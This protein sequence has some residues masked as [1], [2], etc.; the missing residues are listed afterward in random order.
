MGQSWNG[1]LVHDA[2]NVVSDI[3]GWLSGPPGDP[4]RIRQ[5][6]SQIETLGD[7]LDSNRRGLNESIDEL[8]RSWQGDGA[9]QFRE[10]WYGGGGS[11]ATVMSDAHTQLIGFVRGLR[12]YADKLEQAQNEHWIQMGILA[13]LTVVNVAQ[14]GADPATDAAEVGV[15]AT[16][17]VAA[18]FTLASVGTMAI[19]GA[20][21]GLSSDVVAQLGA[22][23]LDHLD[24]AFDQ[25][26]DHATSWFNP[27]EA[28]LS[29]VVGG[30]S[31]VF[32]GGGAAL[33]GI[34]RSYGRDAAANTAADASRAVLD[35]TSDIAVGTDGIAW[36]GGQSNFMAPGEQFAENAAKATPLDGYHDVI[37]HGTPSDFG[38]SPMSWADGSNFGH[39]TLAGLIR[40]D[41]GYAGGPIRLMS[42]GTGGTGATAAQNLANKLGTEVLA[43]SDMLHAFPDGRL[44][45]GRRATVP[46]GEW[47]RFFP[48]VSP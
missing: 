2:G 23:V 33:T 19:E 48:G 44:V 42:C 31:G 26:G 16:T 22:D 13:A 17:E 43:P 25:T 27:Q 24:P 36:P 6:A 7:R 21:V 14:L 39:R 4:G 32:L 8:T 38:P 9:T 5:V 46:S 41:P 30:G 20:F 18:G 35:T 12:D 11:P 47:R 10:T 1:D 45:V 15:A 40:G 37:I 34:L 28:A 29:A 3:G